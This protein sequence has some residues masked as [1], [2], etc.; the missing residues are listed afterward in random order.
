MLIVDSVDSEV[1]VTV[2]PAYDG[3]QP[4]HQAHGVLRPG[5]LEAAHQ[6]PLLRLQVVKLS[7]GQHLVLPPEAAGDE[8]PG[9]G[10]QL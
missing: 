5:E 7:A 1:D 6:L 10:L 8:D 4:G 2:D 9:T 3:G